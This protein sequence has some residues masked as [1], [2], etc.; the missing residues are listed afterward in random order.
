[1]LPTQRT[2]LVE[3]DPLVHEH[4]RLGAALPQGVDHRLDVLLV[5][6]V[7]VDVERRP[8]TSPPRELGVVEA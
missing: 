1:M 7:V 6:D 8:G 4:H 3:I 5:D 2:A